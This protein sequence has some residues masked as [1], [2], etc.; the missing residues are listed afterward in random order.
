MRS[1]EYDETDL[2]NMSLEIHLVKKEEKKLPKKQ[3]K[4]MLNL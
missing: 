4:K 2:E 3:N 1:Y